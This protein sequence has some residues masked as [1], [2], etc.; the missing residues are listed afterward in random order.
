[1]TARERDG[2]V[3]AMTARELDGRVALVTGAAGDI[4]LAIA[5][6]FVDAGARVALVD[7][8]GAALRSRVAEAFGDAPD[9]VLAIE[10]D[11]ADPERSR[12]AVDAALARFGALHLLVNNAAADTPRHP[13]A[14]L[15]IDAWRAALDVNLTGAWLMARWAIPAMRAAGGGVVLNVASQLARVA[16]PGRAAYSASKAGLLALTRSI[17]VDHAADGIRAV[18]LS[19]GAVMTGRLLRRYGDE[20]AVTRALAPRHP[21]GRIATPTEVADAALFL[22]GDRAGFVTGS[23]MLVDGGY[24]AV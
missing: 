19:P 17:A 20:A 15:P 22:V 16:S 21:A 5:R 13:V 12:A 4:G 7:R 9:A 24:T 23:D 14:D 11:V 3:R 18:S 10:A 1:M 6:R 2:R 8:D